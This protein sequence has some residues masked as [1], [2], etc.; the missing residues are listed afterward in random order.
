MEVSAMY[1]EYIWL[2]EKVFGK[3]NIDRE[4]DRALWTFGHADTNWE[5]H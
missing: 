3:Y 5:L 4:T 2:L 1:M